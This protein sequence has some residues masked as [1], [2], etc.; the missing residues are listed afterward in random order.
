[1]TSGNRLARL[2]FGLGADRPGTVPPG[3]CGGRA[4]GPV[5]T[6]GMVV[7][8]PAG[9]L[10]NSS[11]GECDG[12]GD[13]DGGQEGAGLGAQRGEGEGLGGAAGEAGQGG[14][15]YGVVGRH[16]GAGGGPE[17][18]DGGR[19]DVGAIGDRLGDPDDV[20]GGHALRGDRAVEGDS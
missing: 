20:E 2:P 1:V 10:R 7:A 12:L 9:R 13:G 8:P 16:A 3:S 6:G 19:A 11:A 18:L 17:L 14:L 4:S 5:T 15:E